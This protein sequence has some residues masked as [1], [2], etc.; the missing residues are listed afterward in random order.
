[1]PVFSTSIKPTY[2][3]IASQTLSGSS[4]S[5]TFSN[6]P[7]TFTD[8]VIVFSGGESGANKNFNLTFN[9]DSGSNYSWTRLLGDGSTTQSSRGSSQTSIENV[10][11]NEIC[12]AV[13]NVM[14]YSNVTTNKT[15][16]SRTSVASSRAATY[17]GLWRSTAAITSITFTAESTFTINSG[18]TFTIYG[19]ESAKI[20]KATGG[21]IYTDG[22]YWYH[23]FKSSGLFSPTQSITADVLVVAGGG[24][25]G[26]SSASAGGGGAGGVAYYSSQSLISTVY[27]VTVG[28][29]GAAG[30]AGAYYQ[31]TFSP[32][33]GN[34]SV[35]GSLTAA[36]GGGRGGGYGETNGL[37]GGSGGG[38][39]TNSGTGGS[40]TSGQGNSGGTAGNGGNFYS[41]GGGGAGGAGGAGTSGLAV[42][43]GGT[44]TYSS[45]GLAT[46]T[47]QNVSGTYYYAGG[48]GGSS[49]G[50][51]GGAGGNGGGGQ[52]ATANKVG[53]TNGTVSTGGG[54]GGGSNTESVAVTGSQ[55]GSGIVI[56]R[57][58]V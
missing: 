22:T 52:G 53:G 57:Y 9:S 26:L 5:V 27:A 13:Y 35:F 33:N 31:Y 11:S 17:V 34:N 25:G 44:S 6:I 47:G 28:G 38:G 32:T 18:S 19:I 2:T 39:S 40:P 56:V 55:G 36:V 58:A 7:Q 21:T 30:V 49:N 29:G 51:G 41:G 24:A 45:W 23:T 46:G 37:N 43:G 10:L 48:G 14:N 8:L 15:I 16:L 42:G 12:T 20:P 54:G 50:V 1:M 4:A 3:K